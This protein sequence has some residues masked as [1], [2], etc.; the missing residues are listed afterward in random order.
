MKEYK[1]NMTTYR[2][3]KE[4]CEIKKVKISKS[5][6]IS[7]YCRAFWHDDIGIYE[8]FFLLL[9][10]RANIT[11]GYVKISQGGVSGTVADLKIIMKYAIEGLA[12]AVAVIH[13]HPSGNMKPSQTDIELTKRINDSCRLMDISLLDHLI[14]TE[15]D[16]FSFADEGLL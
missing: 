1:S 13:N 3:V 7:E 16:Y 10:N 12:A 4:P 9:M 8:S 6:D 14:V 2:L 15:E 5:A 11:T